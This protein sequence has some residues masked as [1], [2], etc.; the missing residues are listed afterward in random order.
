MILRRRALL[1][2]SSAMAEFK[3]VRAKLENA[4]RELDLVDEWI[5]EFHAVANGEP[6]SDQYLHYARTCDLFALLMGSTKSTATEAEYEAAR[7][8]HPAK[9]IPFLVGAG[10]AATSEFRALLRERHTAPKVDAAEVV[11]AVVS[12]VSDAVHTAQLV[13]PELLARSVQD[14]DRQLALTSDEPRLCFVP[15]ATTSEDPERRLPLGEANRLV[16]GGSS[17]A[18]KSYA[19]GVWLRQ[20]ARTSNAIP[21]A[22]R[23]RSD[24]TD[25]YELIEEAFDAV[26]FH[27]GRELVEGYAREGRIAIALDGFDDLPAAAQERLR[28]SLVAFAERFPRTSLAI[29]ARALSGSI[30]TDV[31]HLIAAPIGADALLSAFE[32]YG[33]PI[34]FVDDI[35]RQFHDLI[36]RPLW[37]ILLAQY[38]TAEESG[39]QLLKRLLDHRLSQAL[40]GNAVRQ[41]K[42]RSLL[43]FVANKIRPRLTASASEFLRHTDKW[44]SSTQTRARFEEETAEEL[45]RA[46]TRTGLVYQ[47]S[48]QVRYAHVLLATALAAEWAVS[49][50]GIPRLPTGDRDLRAMVAASLPEERTGEAVDVLADSDVYT[51]AMALR[52]SQRAPRSPLAFDPQ[53]YKAAIERLGRT[54]TAQGPIMA[55]GDGWVAIR[56]AGTAQAVELSSDEFWEWARPRQGETHRYTMWSPSPFIQRSPLWVA[57]EEA[58]SQFKERVR[59]A[60]PSGDPFARASDKVVTRLIGEPAE[61]RSRVQSAIHEWARIRNHLLDRLE[62]GATGHPARWEAEPT[63]VIR[64][65]AKGARADVKWGQ[66][67]TEFEVLNEEPDYR[68]VSLSELLAPNPAARVYRDLVAAIEQ[69]LGSSTESEAIAAPSALPAMSWQ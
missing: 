11:S 20:R 59:A 60:A 27:P 32:A 55:A 66:A 33:A 15:A 25:L 37:A 41:D 16:L 47:E 31:P 40:P 54:D 7:A 12:A 6:P 2:V 34:R 5:F 29:A 30:L 36:A 50:N 24:Q 21:L 44:S 69:L 63:V 4:V 58:V 9:V 57:A 48:G 17:G 19:L 65:G 3:D 56:D 1:F 39:L 61:L 23:A 13:L 64:I 26:R 22:L 68:G 14:L 46:A 28:E 8:D 10:D 42:L 53:A 52:L 38:G 18:G 43:G 45:L 49:T 67:T 62:L 51:V 35:P